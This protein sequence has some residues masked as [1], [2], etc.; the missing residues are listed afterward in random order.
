[1]KKHFLL[2]VALVFAAQMSWGVDNSYYESL[3]GKKDGELRQALTELLYTK[4]TLFSKYD[5]DFPYDYDSNGNMLDIYSNCGFNSKNNYESSYKCCCDAVNREHV[6]CQSNFGGSGSKDNIPQYSDRHHLFPVDGRA[7]GHRSD[8]PFGECSAGK[9]GTCNSASEVYPEEGTST[10]DNHEYGKSGT[11]TFSVALPS[12]G[13]KVYEVGDDYKGDIARAILYMVVRYADSQHCRLPNEAKYCTS[14]GGGTIASTH[15]LK[16]ANSYPVTAWANTTKDK[17]GQM[18]SNSLSTNHGLSDY[19]KAL[20]LK[21]NGQDAVSPKELSRNDGVEVVQGNRNPFIDHP[22]L[23]EYL[24][25]DKQGEEFILDDDPTPTPTTK[26]AITWSVKGA[27]SSDEV[28]EGDR[29]SAPSVTNCSS[30]R[31]FVGWTTSSTVVS[32]PAVLYASNEIPTAYSNATYY[33]VFADKESLGSGGD[34]ELYDGDLT[35]GDYVIYYGGKAMKA[36]V[37]SSRFDYTGVAPTNHTIS[38]P[39]ADIVWHIAPSST[40]WTI[41]NASVQKYAAGN[42]TKNQGALIDKGSEDAALWTAS[43]SETYEFVNKYNTAQSVNA[44]LRNNGTY[45]FACYATQI[46]GE[47]SLYKS[48]ESTVT[49]SHYGLNCTTIADVNVTFYANDGTSNTLKQVVPEGIATKLLP[50]S[51]DREHYTFL[52]WATTADG[53]KVY[54]DEAY[55][56]TATDLDLYAVWQEDPKYTVSFMNNGE[57]YKNVTGYVGTTITAITD[58]TVCDGYTFVGWSTEQYA[59]DNTNVPVTGTP[60]AITNGNKTYYAVYSREV[61]VPGSA[62]S[63]Y[64]LFD[65]NL[66][67]GD[68]V[69]YYS[70]KAMKASTFSAARLEYKEITPSGSTISSPTADIVWHIAPSGDYW[71]I[72]NAS[73]QKYAASTGTQNQATLNADKT[74]EKILWT[75]SDKYEFTNKYNTDQKV[76]ATLRNNT[77]YGFACYSIK[78]GGALSLYKKDASSDIKTTYYTTAPYCVPEP[79]YSVTFMAYGSQYYQTNGHEGDAIDLVNPDAPCAK[80]VFYGWS[81]YEYAESNTDLP[82]L[83]DATVIPNEDVTYYAVYSKAEEA[84]NMPTDKF[85]KITTMDELTDDNY[86]IV[87]DTS[88]LLAMSSVIFN[89]YPKSGAVT[90]V[91][92]VITTNGDTIIWQITKDP[93]NSQISIYNSVNGYLYI[94]MEE[95]NGKTY[96]N[97]KIGSTTTGNIFTYSVNDGKWVLSSATY[98]VRQLEYYKSSKRWTIYTGQDAPIYL[99]KQQLGKGNIYYYTTAPV[100]TDTPTSTDAVMQSAPA[101]RKLLIDGQLFILRDGKIYTIQG[102]KVQ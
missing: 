94:E 54:N 52:G 82:N 62:S 32:K 93:E 10:C 8:L 33:A 34:Y 96:Y 13:G 43:G 60:T 63:D 85:K 26:Y 1:M 15:S 70:G 24:W 74:D 99:Y 36:S 49:Y 102:A 88:Q 6:V 3:V 53:A 97:L 51:F 66:T 87:A 90:A 61:I 101:V 100:C 12:G 44:N 5:W 65:G 79:E 57:E 40:Y 41:Y 56:T 64:N 80:Y 45:G 19:G 2:W 11:S 21:W 78:T 30:D 86:L 18:F 77:T 89:Y 20:L 25:G 29:P 16:T 83:V 73:V 48:S 58:P 42:G 14:S 38:N 22:E 95:K 55:V 17:V 27:T 92:D 31:V 71:T 68:Y 75:A 9:H 72:Y 59:T 39:D 23:V 50:N 91:E 37:S 98:S 67:E 69:I 76:N 4:H 28:T 7:N 47:L 84:D 46:G 35:E 81:A